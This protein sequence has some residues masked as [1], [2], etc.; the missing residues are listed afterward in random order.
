MRYDPYTG[1]FGMDFY[2]VLGRPGRRVALRKRKS[3][4]IGKIFK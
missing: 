3:G 4:R 1:I 2:V